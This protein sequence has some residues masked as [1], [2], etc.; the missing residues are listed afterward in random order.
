MKNI[1]DMFGVYIG[2]L[3]GGLLLCIPLIQGIVSSRP[4][5]TNNPTVYTTAKAESIVKPIETTL[6]TGKPKQIIIESVGIDLPVEVGLY[7]PSLRTWTLNDTSAFYAEIT[8][9]PNNKEGNTFI[10]GHNESS[11]FESLPG[12]NIGDEARVITENGLQFTYTLAGSK[13]TTP[14]DLELFNY[15]G[16][17]ILTLQTCTGIWM[18]NRTLFVFSLKEVHQL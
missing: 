4:L 15:R 10:Y 8:P 17:P 3:L 14:E 7:N 2:F 11:V 16:A 1:R 12:V 13:Q 9:E 18:E 5:D 6:L